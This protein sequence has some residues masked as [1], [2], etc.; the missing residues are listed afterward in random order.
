MFE[1]DNIDI[2]SR[3]LQY[4]TEFLSYKVIY[5]CRICKNKIPTYWN[6][7]TID[8]NFLADDTFWSEVLDTTAHYPNEIVCW[9]CL[10]ER[11]RTRERNR[12]LIYEY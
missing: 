8:G 12:K 4:K 2:V 6:G 9:D 1:V 5:H 7:Y 10:D 3:M 11:A